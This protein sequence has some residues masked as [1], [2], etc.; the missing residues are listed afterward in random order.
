MISGDQSS[1]KSKMERIFPNKNNIH[2]GLDPIQKLEYIKELQ[3][4]GKKVMMVGDGLNDAGALKQSDAGVAVSD[5]IYNFSP[6]CDA[7][8]NS[9]QLHLLNK[10]LSYCKSSSTIV[11]FS[12][13]ISLSYNITGL[14]FATSAHLSPMIAAILMPASSVSV[15]LFVIG[16][17]NLFAK[18]N[19]LI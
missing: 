12:L 8:V 1:D 19:S 18:R 4:Q 2:F 14:V 3:S 11:K 6:S 7:I 16:M 9:N 10:F 13:L 5:D 17:S 15:V